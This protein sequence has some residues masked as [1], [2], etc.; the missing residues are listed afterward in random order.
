MTRALVIKKIGNT[1]FANAIENGIVST[2]VPLD[3]GELAAV[4]AE[5]DTLKAAQGV[6]KYADDQAWDEIKADMD[7]TYRVKTHGVVYHK[8]ILA[9]ALVWLTFCECVRRLQRWNREG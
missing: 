3:S 1:E 4:R 8:I 2:I 6:R 7:A 5:N 9:W